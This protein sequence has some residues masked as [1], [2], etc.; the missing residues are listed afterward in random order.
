VIDASDHL[1]AGERA[2]KQPHALPAAIRILAAPDST[3]FTIAVGIAGP[4]L[5]LAFDPVVFKGPD[6]VFGSV[7]VLCY[8]FIAIEI[9]V[10]SV[11]LLA[12]ERLRL[13][14]G[15]VGGTLLAGSLLAAGLG[16]VLLP[17]S[18]M[19]LMIVI[20]VFG[21]TPFLTAWVF[22]WRGVAAFRCAARNLPKWSL[23]PSLVLGV[24]LAL[25]LPY[26]IDSGVRRAWQ[27][28]VRDLANGDESAI[29]RV[30]VLH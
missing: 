17:F 25:A 30:R 14:S 20:G 21:F 9:L 1:V 24:A 29:K 8:S 3:G 6:A 11:W 2:A 13:V 5:C 23:A 22:G 10:L 18:V 19:G 15:V 7:R 16:A 4:L 28:A 27:R 12:K 26:S